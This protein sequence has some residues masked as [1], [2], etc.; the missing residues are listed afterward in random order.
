M[1]GDISPLKRFHRFPQSPQRHR[2]HPFLHEHAEHFGGFVESPIAFRIGIDPGHRRK[3]ILHAIEPDEA[4]LLIPVLDAAADMGKLVGRHGGVANKD[5]FVVLGVAIE[6]APG[7]DA[8]GVAAA[9]VLPNILVEAVVIIVKLEVFELV[10]GGGEKFGAGPD[11]IVHRASDIH[12]EEDAYAIFAGG[13][14]VDVQHAGVF[15]S[16]PN[17]FVEVELIGMAFAGEDAQFA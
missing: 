5:D 12:E 6:E 14:H 7:R 13:L 17:G 15:G 3:L 9:V 11:V 10:F 2:K 4:G 16:L 1:V 8:L